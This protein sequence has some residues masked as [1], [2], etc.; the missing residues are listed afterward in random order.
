LLKQSATL[1]QITDSGRLYVFTVRA[2]N[3]SFI[4]SLVLLT[5]CFHNLKVTPVSYLLVKIV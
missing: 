2:V 3:G 5:C 4:K 1:A